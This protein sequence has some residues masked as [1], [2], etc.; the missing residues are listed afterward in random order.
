[1]NLSSPFPHHVATMLAIPSF[2]QPSSRVCMDFCSPERIQLGQSI[3][4]QLG[5]SEVDVKRDYITP[6]RTNSIPLFF[7]SHT[8]LAHLA[9]K[10]PLLDNRPP[11]P[12]PQTHKWGSAPSSSPIPAPGSYLVFSVFA[13][14]ILYNTV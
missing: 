14:S 11:M 12:P 9:T 3:Q 7:L 6:G 4:K 1:M 2:W 10:L 5:F 8:P 13:D